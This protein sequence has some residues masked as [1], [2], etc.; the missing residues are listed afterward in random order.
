MESSSIACGLAIMLSAQSV[1]AQR[2]GGQRPGGQGGFGG[3]GGQNGLI[4]MEAV[5]KELGIT[6]EQK[7]KITKTT[8]EARTAGRE[9]FGGFR[10]ASEAERAKMMEKMQAARKETQT[11]IEA[12]LT[13]EQKT[14]LR[15]CPFQEMGTRALRTEEVQAELK[16]SDEQ[17]KKLDVVSAAGRQNAGGDRPQRP[18]AESMAAREKQYLDVL[19]SD[20]QAAFEKMKG[21]KFEFPQQGRGGFGGNAG[22][23][24]PQR[25]QGGDRPQRGGGD[26]PAPGDAPKEPARP[27]PEL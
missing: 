26:R 25:G 21:K 14:R 1:F 10:D 19:T 13:T 18:T 15:N 5:Q 22:G 2:Q 12:L 27:A 16:L 23:D 8:E 20:Q 11:K 4:S 6:S 3:Q 24:R 17:K 7:E 9:G